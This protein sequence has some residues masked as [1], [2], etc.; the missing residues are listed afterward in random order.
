MREYRKKYRKNNK[1]QIKEGI[2]RYNE[3]N[4]GFHREYLRKNHERC[5]RVMNKRQKERYKTDKNFVISRR[6]R[7]DLKGAFVRFIKTGKIMSSKKY[8]I[9]YFKIIEHLKPFPEDLSNYHIHHI[10]PLFTFNFI[11]HDGS[12][13]LEEIK[14]AFAPKNHQ[15]L[16]IKEHRKLNHVEV[17]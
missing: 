14:K 5:R 4:P 8:R 3:N 2:K 7:G 15:W 9:D 16:T 13:N 10:K 6:L 12:T 11:N 17:K 1:E